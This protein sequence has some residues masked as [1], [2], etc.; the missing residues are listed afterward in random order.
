MTF[1]PPETFPHDCMH[2][3]KKVTLFA[4][5]NLERY[6]G[7]IEN[8]VCAI[9]TEFELSDL[10]KVTSVWRNEYDGHAGEWQFSREDADG[11]SVE[12]RVAVLRRDTID[13]VT[14]YHLED[15]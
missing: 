15:V 7:K 11:C 14:T 10:P 6:A 1:T 2:R 13:G 4:R 3:G 9:F 8:G 5:D 12:N